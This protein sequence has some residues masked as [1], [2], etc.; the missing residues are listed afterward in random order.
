M[1]R[2]SVIVPVY[3]RAA[4]VL[5]TLES[6]CDQTFADFECIVVDDGSKDGEELRAIV[7]ELGDSRFRYVRRENGG[8]SAARN[9]GI[10]EARGELIA[11]L[12][13]DDQWLPE[14]LSMQLVRLREFPDRIAYCQ[15][16]VDRGVRKQWLRPRRGIGETEDVG[17][18]LFVANE[19]IP[20]PTV[21]LATS[22]ARSFPWDE[23]LRKAEDLDLALRLGKAGYRFEF[24]AEPLVIWT[25]TTEEH[26]ASK[27]GGAADAQKFLTKHKPL[28]TPKAES[29][30]RVSYLACELARM[31]RFGAL[32]ELA[33]GARSGISAKVVGRHLLRVLL[34]RQAYRTLVDLV[35]QVAGK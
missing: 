35:V 16:L 31:D 5:P 23:S 12:D 26:R 1:P 10:D 3:N 28:L 9:T 20:T 14:K 33:A 30:F 8:A 18:Y 4:T 24:V 17:E 13:S 7:E 19:F 6:V 25:D 29:G 32:R 11:F 27:A 2:F 15:C 22:I 21:A 34:P